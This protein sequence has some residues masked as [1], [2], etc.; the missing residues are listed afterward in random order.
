MPRSEATE[1][2]DAIGSLFVDPRV[3][4]DPFAGRPASDADPAEGQRLYV[5]LGCRACHIIGSSGGY[6]GPPLS[7]SGSRLRPGW[8]FTWLK[9]PQRW[10]ADVRCPD[11]ALTDLDALRLT[12]YLAGLHAAPGA[13][14]RGSP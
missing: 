5:T 1:L 8:T 11:Y 4:E 14:T 6:Y 9:G 13:Q 12:A 3:P 7:D 2:A 10:R